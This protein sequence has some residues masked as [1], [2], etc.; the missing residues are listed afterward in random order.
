ML[1]ARR[2]LEV[3]TGVQ[4]HSSSAV[5]VPFSHA[6]LGADLALLLLLLL[7]VAAALLVHG[8]GVDVRPLLAV[9]A[10]ARLGADI[11]LPLLAVASLPVHGTG[12]GGW[13]LL[14]VARL[15]AAG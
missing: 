15:G 11:A 14:A 7:L 2:F 4:V 5:V 10:F 8:A 3:G 9:V 12:V 13:P 1:F 6:Q